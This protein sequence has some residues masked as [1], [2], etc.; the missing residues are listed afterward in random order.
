M[1][2]WE[3]FVVIVGDL[4]PSVVILWDF[5]HENAKVLKVI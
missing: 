1:E 2:I 3:S 5:Q 4:K